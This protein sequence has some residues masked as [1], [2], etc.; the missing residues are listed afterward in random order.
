ML[1]LFRHVA[2]SNETLTAAE[3]VRIPKTNEPRSGN[4]M[5]YSRGPDK[6]GRRVRTADGG[7]R[8]L[9]RTPS[10]TGNCSRVDCAVQNSSFRTWYLTLDSA[11]GAV[12]VLV[13]VTVNSCACAG[14]GWQWLWALQVGAAAAAWAG[15]A[16]WMMVP[17]TGLV[18]S[19][20]FF[21]P[22]AAFGRAGLL[23]FEQFSRNQSWLEEYIVAENHNGEQRKC[24]V[25]KDFVVAYISWPG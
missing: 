7:R 15:L 9:S 18:L 16:R 1:P 8:L 22:V 10:G 11:G 3:G 4:R 13:P 24:R 14:G 2:F 23:A 21:W 25:R 12:I 17:V 20:G 19:T 6:V 5:T